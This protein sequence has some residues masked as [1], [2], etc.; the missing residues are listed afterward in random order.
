MKRN[1]KGKTAGENHPLY[2]KHHT[3]EA[4]KKISEGH[5]GK[6]PRLG[7]HLSKE[8]KKKIGDANRGKPSVFKGRHHTEESKDKQIENIFIKQNKILLENP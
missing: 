6:Q 2:G 8:A 4:R 5:K 7:A 3:K 1:R